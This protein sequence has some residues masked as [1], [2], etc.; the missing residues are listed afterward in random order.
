MIEATNGREGHGV[1][2]IERS[3]VSFFD[4]ILKRLRHSKDKQ[5]QINDAE[6][7]VE[8]SCSERT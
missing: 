8:R 6:V 1:T 5:S 4:D 3:G 2:P 7:V